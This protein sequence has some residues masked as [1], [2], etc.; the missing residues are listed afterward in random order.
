VLS[1]HPGSQQA[2]RT[3]T[4][5]QRQRVQLPGPAE[6]KTSNTRADG[7]WQRQSPH[8]RPE[9]QPVGQARTSGSKALPAARA[10][11]GFVA[12]ALRSEGRLGFRV[13]PGNPREQIAALTIQL[14]WREYQRRAASR[15]PRNPAVAER[16][17]KRAARHRQMET[18]YR[19]EPPFAP[20]W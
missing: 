16:Q 7:S 4:Q 17:E 11:P 19:Q 15:R 9:K 6:R 8:R 12:G 5:R 2:S 14:R 10:S 3:P 18:A 13:D 1:Q 20:Q